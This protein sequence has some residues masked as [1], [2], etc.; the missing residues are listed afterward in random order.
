MESTILTIRKLDFYFL[1]P[2]IFS[3]DIYATFQL[4]II[5]FKILVLFL[6]GSGADGGIDE[7]I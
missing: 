2:Q 5:K 4:V 3:L 6:I 1:L 7:H